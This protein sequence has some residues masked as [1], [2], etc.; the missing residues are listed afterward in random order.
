MAIDLELNYLD[1]KYCKTF[2][3]Q[4]KSLRFLIGKIQQIDLQICMYI[5]LATLKRYIQSLYAFMLFLFTANYQ[6]DRLLT[7]TTVKSALQVITVI[8]I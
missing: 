2:F 7:D 8:Q 5:K 1:S 6:P 4:S 3:V